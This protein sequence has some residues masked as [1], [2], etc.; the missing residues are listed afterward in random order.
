M[1]EKN[2]LKAKI[3]DQLYEEWAEYYHNMIQLS[4]PML[5]DKA[6]EITAK[7]EVRD[8]LDFY[9]HNCSDEKA[10]F[11][12]SQFTGIINHFYDQ[13]LKRDDSHFEEVYDSVSFTV[14]DLAKNFD[15]APK[16]D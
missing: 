6:Y 16:M 9:I 3:E 11:V 8:A 12:L 5:F 1:D 15:K 4:S 2:V 13:W 7:A 14:E 10:L